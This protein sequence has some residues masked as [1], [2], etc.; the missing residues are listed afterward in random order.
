MTVSNESVKTTVEGNGAITVFTYNFPIPVNADY[1]LIY[2]D[3]EGNETVLGSSLYSITGLGSPNGGSFTYPLSGSP[4]AAGTTLTL[5]RQVPYAQLT[6]FGNQTTY[7]PQVLEAALDNIVEQIQQV[8]ENVGRCLQIPVVE[9]TPGTLPG[10]QARENHLLGFDQN[11]APIA[12][13][14][15]GGSALPPNS[16]DFY[17]FCYGQP[18]SSQ[19]IGQIVFNRAIVFGANMPGMQGFAGV[20]PTTAVSITMNYNGVPIGTINFAEGAQTSTT[21]SNAFTTA[22]GGVL[23]LVFQATTDATFANISVTPSGTSAT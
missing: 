5:L 22:A 3:N 2:T 11:G 19:I 14:Y 8:V 16:Q 4:I 18:S 23:S 20:A 21:V 7:N 9:Q 15:P 12:V 17:F 1:E 13:A 6:N 10:Q